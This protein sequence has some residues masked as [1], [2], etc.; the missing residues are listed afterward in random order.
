MCF[1]GFLQKIYFLLNGLLTL[2]LVFSYSSVASSFSSPSLPAPSGSA[3]VYLSVTRGARVISPLFSSPLP[4]I[5]SHFLSDVQT[6]VLQVGSSHLTSL[7]EGGHS[8]ESCIE[9]R[10]VMGDR[11][12]GA[13]AWLPG[14]MQRAHRRTFVRRFLLFSSKNL[15]ARLTEWRKRCQQREAARRLHRGPEEVNS[16]DSTSSLG[17]LSAIGP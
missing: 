5:M 8:L 2:C 9:G 14:L 13:R 16:W 17:D 7:S 12:E 10:A 11:G 6:D 1:P 4:L 15:L 3:C